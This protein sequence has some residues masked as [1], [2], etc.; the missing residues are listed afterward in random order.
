MTRLRD[1]NT[2]PSSTHYLT[3][4]H[5]WGRERIFTLLRSNFESFYQNIDTAK[6]PKTFQD[7]LWMTRRLGFKHLWID[8]LC[9]IQDSHDDWLKEAPQMGEV[10]RNATLNLAATGFSDGRK[11]LFST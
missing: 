8:S 5:C 6:L 7:A 1:G 3:L 11:G 4:S 2:L 10:Y 9:I